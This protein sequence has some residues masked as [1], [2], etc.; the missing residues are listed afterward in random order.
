MKPTVRSGFV[1]T[2]VVLAALGVGAAMISLTYVLALVF[3]ALFVALGLDPV[4]GTLEKMGLGRVK[5]VLGVVAALLGLCRPGAGLGDPPVGRR[6][7]EAAGLVALGPGRRR[8]PGVVHRA[9]RYPRWSTGGALLEHWSP[10][11]SGCGAPWSTPRCGWRRATAPRRP[12]SG[13]PT[14]SSGCSS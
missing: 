5:T 12:A 8:I 9:Q 4:V 1:V 2:L 10:A 7:P 3:V 6:W 14:A 13:S 11:S